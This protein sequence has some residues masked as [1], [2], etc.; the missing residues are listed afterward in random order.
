MGWYVDEEKVIYTAKMITLKV[1]GA[2]FGNKPEVCGSV[3]FN[4]AD[5]INALQHT[6]GKREI[7]LTGTINTAAKP[8]KVN[9]TSWTVRFE[10]SLLTSDEMVKELKK[11]GKVRLEEDKPDEKAKVLKQ[12]NSLLQEAM[13]VCAKTGESVMEYL[14]KHQGDVAT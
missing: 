12:E 5:Y 11:E 13:R 1:V 4:I 9:A 7:S 3:E 14:R 8:G 10:L 2:V 6:S